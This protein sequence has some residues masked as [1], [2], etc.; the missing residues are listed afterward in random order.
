MALARSRGRRH[1]PRTEEY[2][3]HEALGYALG[4]V[5]A[6]APLI[7][8]AVHAGYTR[9][10]RA[11]VAAAASGRITAEHLREIEAAGEAIAKAHGVSAAPPKKRRKR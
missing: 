7:S 2:L 3:A 10:L 8:V 6:L 1:A 4:K 9:A 11:A 5:C